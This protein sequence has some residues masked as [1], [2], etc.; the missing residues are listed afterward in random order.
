M[1][2]PE[3]IQWIQDKIN[4]NDNLPNF[5][6]EQ[7]KHILSKLNEAVSF[8]NFLH[9]NTSEKRFSLEGGE[10]IIPAL[11]ALIEAAAEKA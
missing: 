5:N 4:V 9:T 1:R 6:A 11:D 10:T 7:K 2:H 3:T 8:E